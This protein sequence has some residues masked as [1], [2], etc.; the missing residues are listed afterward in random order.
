MHCAWP[1]RIDDDATHLG[2]VADE[3]DQII[4]AAPYKSLLVSLCRLVALTLAEQKARSDF[5]LPLMGCPQIRLKLQGR[6]GGY[7]LCAV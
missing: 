7:A 1:G 3:L 2:S 5:P 6:Y 4:H